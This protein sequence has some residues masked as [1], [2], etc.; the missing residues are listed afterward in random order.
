[1]VPNEDIA[2]RSTDPVTSSAALASPAA[3]VN[4]LPTDSNAALIGDQFSTDAG[5]S[6]KLVA[7]VEFQVPLLRHALRTTYRA[8]D[9]P[10]PLPNVT[11][12]SIKLL[13]M[14]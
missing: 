4:T 11:E 9:L 10:L 14:L 12:R 5:N 2:T 6:F 13:V 7:N 3:D 1:M 8:L